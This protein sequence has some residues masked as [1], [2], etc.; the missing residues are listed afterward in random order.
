MSLPQTTNMHAKCRLPAGNI[1]GSS[2]SSEAE[3][4]TTTEPVDAIPPP[5]PDGGWTAWLQ[6][7]GAFFLFFNSW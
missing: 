2:G 5:P 3:K 6:V 1:T 4:Q 7:A